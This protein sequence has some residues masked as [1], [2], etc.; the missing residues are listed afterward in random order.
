MEDSSKTSGQSW[1]PAAVI[2]CAVGSCLLLL[3]WPFLFALSFGAARGYLADKTDWPKPF[4]SAFDEDEIEIHGL[5]A[6]FDNPVIA[7]VVG[8]HDLV[9]ELVHRFALELA[10]ASHPLASRLNQLMPADWLKWPHSEDDR[11]YTTKDFGS[12]HLEGR[13]LFLVVTNRKSDRSLIYYNW[14]L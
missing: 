4:A 7:Q 13:D 2:T 11:W 10:D 6:F 5:P 3:A 1:L 12:V 14:I 8:H 9:D